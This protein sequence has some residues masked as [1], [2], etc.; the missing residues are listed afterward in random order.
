MTVPHT[1][2]LDVIR[3]RGSIRRRTNPP[4]DRARI[5][6]ALDAAT[7]APSAHNRRIHLQSI[8]CPRPA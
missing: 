4:V 6:M 1:A 7:Y 2:V 8:E 3:A 5:D